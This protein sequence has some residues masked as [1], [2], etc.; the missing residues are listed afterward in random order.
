MKKGQISLDLLLSLLIA[1]I[2]VSSFYA[3][4]NNFKQFDEQQLTQQQL[5]TI[6][7]NTANLIS[8]TQALNDT[9]FIIKL[10][11]K[12]IQYIDA[13]NTAQ[14]VY[15]TPTI[16][17]TPDENKLNLRIEIAPGKSLDHNSTIVIGE[18]TKIDISGVDKNGILV[19]R[20]E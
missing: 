1:L 15:P 2:I 11:V 20:N 5:N 16:L 18:R 4:I 6:T 9:N 8:S 12:K 7:E 17:N 13:N 14:S 10:Q 19:I 3:L